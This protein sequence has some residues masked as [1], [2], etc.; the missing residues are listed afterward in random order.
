MTDLTSDSAHDTKCSVPDQDILQNTIVDY[1]FLDH[2]TQYK[3]QQKTN[4]LSMSRLYMSLYDTWNVNS[5][6][7]FNKQRLLSE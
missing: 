1:I 4:L 2:S 6:S 5:R 7:M 3:V